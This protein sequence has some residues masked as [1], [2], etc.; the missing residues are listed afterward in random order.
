M[1]WLFNGNKLLNAETGISFEV[2]DSDSGYESHLS[3][4]IPS[5]EESWNRQIFFEGTRDECV[6]Q[7]HELVDELG[8]RQR[9]AKG[10]PIPIIPEDTS[11]TDRVKFDYDPP[12]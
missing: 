2:Y 8:A 12:F 3:Q 4:Y 6:L 5:S 7:L 10:T 1:T 11:I 9:P